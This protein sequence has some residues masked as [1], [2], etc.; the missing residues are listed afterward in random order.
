MS[1]SIDMVSIKLVS[2]RKLAS[3]KPLNTPQDV[4]SLLEDIYKD[5]D[6]EMF[7]SINLQTDLKP[8]NLHVVSVGT[9]NST[10]ASPVNILKPALL[11]NAAN[12]I[13]AHNHPS[14]NLTPSTQDIDAAKKINECCEL[15][16]IHL[17]DSIIFDGKKSNQ[18]YSMRSESLV[19]FDSY[20][21]NI[22]RFND[23]IFY[24]LP[25][26]ARHRID[27]TNITKQL[28]NIKVKFQKSQLFKD[29]LD[30]YNINSNSFSAEQLLQLAQG[31]EK[32]ID[33]EQY[34][35]PEYDADNMSLIRTA[36]EKGLDKEKIEILKQPGFN[37]EQRLQI[38]KGLN[39]NIDVSQYSDP[40]FS[41]LQMQQ[42]RMG[43][44]DD[45]DIS[46]YRY[47]NFNDK[48][49]DI[50]RR[51]LR[52]N[53]YVCYADTKF[54][55]AQMKQLYDAQMQNQDVS[56]LADSSISSEQ[57]YVLK[58]ILNYTNDIKKYVDLDKNELK[59]V[60]QSLRQNKNK[61]SIK[62]TK[63]ISR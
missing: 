7:I 57:M 18:L 27:R 13:I 4:M 17:L 50:I 36:I 59:G 49:M 52:N 45:L 3:E 39:Q 51:G 62:D 60:L 12:V 38:F 21:K 42:L 47:Y 55:E 6:R 37:H 9:L 2:D 29:L 10:I 5:L 16:G 23:S 1:N 48:Q 30:K 35:N 44:A 34:F 20:N 26:E 15:M 11:S 8:I 40:K 46:V 33:I 31:Y 19:Y 32:M 56:V 58:K 63:D 53:I 24:R 25:D 61:S 41:A 22:S 43:L 28:E 14:G 54:S